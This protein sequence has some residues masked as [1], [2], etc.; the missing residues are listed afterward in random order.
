MEERRIIEDFTLR[1][2]QPSPTMQAD[3][4]LDLLIKGGYSSR[5]SQFYNRRKSDYY[6][7]PNVAH[8]STSNSIK[9]L[10][11]QDQRVYSNNELNN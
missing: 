5:G 8:S 10:T 2:P 9:R 1:L 3:L 7:R 4:D 11:Y 6:L